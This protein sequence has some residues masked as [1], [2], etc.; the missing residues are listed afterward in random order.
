MPA[1][2]E[3]QKNFM[4]MVLAEKKGKLK[5]KYKSKEIENAARSMALKS[6]MDYTKSK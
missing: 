2:S 6:I 4:R 3:K 1:K 5:G